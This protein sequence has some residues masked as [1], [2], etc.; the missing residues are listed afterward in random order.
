MPRGTFLPVEGRVCHV[1]VLLIHLFRRQS[2]RLATAL[3]MHD[4]PLTQ[5][6]NNV[7]YIRVI[8]K[9]QDIVI[10]GSGLLLW[11]NQKRTT[12]S[13]FVENI[14]FLVMHIL[15]LPEMRDT[16]APAIQQQ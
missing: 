15:D 6:A 16:D 14:R 9:P 4:L 7:V 10:G 3:I 8:G 12:W 2:Q 11:R 1:E 5:E 13:K